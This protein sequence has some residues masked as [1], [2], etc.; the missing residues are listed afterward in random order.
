M[1]NLGLSTVM[2]HELTSGTTNSVIV[3]SSAKILLKNQRS[4]ADV[5]SDQ[6]VAKITF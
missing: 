3:D 6:T 2:G 5:K 4:M 1:H